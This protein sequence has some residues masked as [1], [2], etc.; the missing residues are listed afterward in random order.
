MPYE[1]VAC[2]DEQLANQ[3]IFVS[4]RP[5]RLSL[6]LVM[7]VALVLALFQTFGQRLVQ[8]VSDYGPVSDCDSDSEMVEG[9]PVDLD[10]LDLFV[11]VVGGDVHE[12]EDFIVDL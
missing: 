4:T 12:E 5:H 1:T 10:D 8:T 9:A 3:L 7:V 6:A 11:D 2:F